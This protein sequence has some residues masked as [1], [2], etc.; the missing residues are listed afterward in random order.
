MRY[1][2]SRR[3]AGQKDT[4][5]LQP[6]RSVLSACSPDRSYNKSLYMIVRLANKI[7]GIPEKFKK[8]FQ[9]A[10]IGVWALPTRKMSVRAVSPKRP[11]LPMCTDTGCACYSLK[12]HIRRYTALSSLKSRGRIFYRN[13]RVSVDKRRKNVRWKVGDIFTFRLDILC[14]NVRCKVKEFLIFYCIDHQRAI[15]CPL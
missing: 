13:F 8:Y 4:S 3:S 6:S 5:W 12:S 11:F 15:L 7:K 2:T 1:P 9:I 10:Q 14:S